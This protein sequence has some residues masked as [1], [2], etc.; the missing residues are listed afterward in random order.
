[1]YILHVCLKFWKKKLIGK[2]SETVITQEINIS[3]IIKTSSV[4]NVVFVVGV[5]QTVIC[6]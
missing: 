2:K 6:F 3:I 5:K 1:M 4:D